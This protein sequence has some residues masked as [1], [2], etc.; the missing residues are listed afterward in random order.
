MWCFKSSA[1]SC[2]FYRSLGE[3]DPTSHRIYDG[4]KHLSDEFMFSVLDLSLNMI[5]I[6]VIMVLFEVKCTIK[7]FIIE[8]RFKKNQAT[9][10]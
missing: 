6:F 8:T 7:K 4:S 10:Y 9:D 5:F 1:V 2:Q 3:N